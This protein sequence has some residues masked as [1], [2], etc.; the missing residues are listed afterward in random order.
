MTSRRADLTG[1]VRRRR[2]RAFW[3]G[4]YADDPSFF[5]EGES[6]FARWCLPRL[7]ADRRIREIVE[8]GCGYGRDTRFF[9]AQGFRIRGVDFAGVSPP[10]RRRPEGPCEFVESDCQRFL[11]RQLPESVDAIYS[12]MLF[13]MDFTRAEHRSLFAAVRRVLRPGGLHLYSVRSTTDPWYGR[14]RRVGPDTFDPAPQ[15]ITMH[16]FSKEYA[17]RLGADGFE[18]V[19]RT[20]RAEGEQDFPVRLWYVVDRKPGRARGP[21]RAGARGGT[22]RAVVR[23]LPARRT[24]RPA[25]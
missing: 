2:Q 3:R 17:D 9:G 18:P 6:D 14:G 16:Y 24:R 15:G 23:K 12:N 7:R 11:A 21:R 25:T 19:V 4:K 20:E 10:G 22:E 13:N 1:A 5:G 8:L